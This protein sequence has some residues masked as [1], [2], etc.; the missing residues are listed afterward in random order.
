MSPAIATIIL[1]TFSAWASSRVR[2]GSF[3][4]FVSPSTMCATSSPKSALDALERDR[5]VLHRV[6]QERRLQRG[7]V[8]P[9]LRQDHRDRERVLDERLAGQAHLALVRGLR[10]EVGALQVLRSAFGL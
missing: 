1:R 4:S 9:E 7:G 3:S 10:R 2:E 5:R 6:V 8:Q